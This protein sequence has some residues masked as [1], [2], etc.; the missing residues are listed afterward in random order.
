VKP[1]SKSQFNALSRI[2][3][4]CKPWRGHNQITGKEEWWL[5]F[6][7][8]DQRGESF[9]TNTGRA[10]AKAGYIE[11]TGALYWRLTD[12]GRAALAKESGPA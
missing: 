7:N 12:A 3:N 1:L 8:P 9:N 4:G 11:P 2:A 10:L 5:A 6:D